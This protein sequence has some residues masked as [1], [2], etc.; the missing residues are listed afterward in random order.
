M[1]I[2][3]GGLGLP[4]NLYMQF[5]IPNLMLDSIFETPSCKY[6]LIGVALWHAND[7]L[8]ESCGRQYP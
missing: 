5:S 3:T 7:R 1:K 4:G 6:L 8:V 2:C